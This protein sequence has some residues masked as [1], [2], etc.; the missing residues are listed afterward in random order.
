[1]IEGISDIVVALE[2]VDTVLEDVVT[3]MEEPVTGRA[4]E[5]FKWE[6][7]PFTLSFP[8]TPRDG[9]NSLSPLGSTT[10]ERQVELGGTT[11]LYPES[12]QTG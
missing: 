1:M 7:N 9:H 3:V 2:L 11:S 12:S 4:L 5:A 6:I 8:R 10:P